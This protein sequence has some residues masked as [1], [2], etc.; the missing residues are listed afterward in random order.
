VYLQEKHLD[1]RYIERGFRMLGGIARFLRKVATNLLSII[2][3]T[4]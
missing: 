1:F 4:S 2:I 3:D